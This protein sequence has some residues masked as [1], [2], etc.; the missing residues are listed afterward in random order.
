MYYTDETLDSSTLEASESVR[1]VDDLSISDTSLGRRRLKLVSLGHKLFQL[2]HSLPHLKDVLLSASTS[3]WFIDSKGRVFQIQKT[4][5]CKL[6]CAKI[7]N[8]LPAKDTT[9]CV[10]VLK[11]IS[12]RY[13]LSYRPHHTDQYAGLLHYGGGTVLYGI[14]KEPFKDTWRKA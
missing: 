4:H 12:T 1:L 8:I 2:K 7:Q 9:G 14:Y 11:G 10:L 5:R 13:K 3:T 6:T